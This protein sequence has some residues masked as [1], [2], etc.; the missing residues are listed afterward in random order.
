M[1][2]QELELKRAE[3]MEEKD[4]R[5]GFKRPTVAAPTSILSAPS[6][7]GKK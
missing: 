5:W 4:G 1:K 6:I 7:P 3:E 2:L